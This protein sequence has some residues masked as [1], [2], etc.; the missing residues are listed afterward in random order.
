VSQARLTCG[1]TASQAPFAQLRIKREY[2]TSYAGKDPLTGREVWLG[3]CQGADELVG[4]R[5]QLARNRRASL[6]GEG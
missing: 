1:R 4:G 5:A 6:A 2:L 3:V